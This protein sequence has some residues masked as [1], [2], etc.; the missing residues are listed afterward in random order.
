MTSKYRNIAVCTMTTTVTNS[1][2]DGETFA[3]I[4]VPIHIS[5]GIISTLGNLL[6][7]EATFRNKT[8]KKTTNILI[9]SLAFVDIAIGIVVTP[10]VIMNMHYVLYVEEGWVKCVIL[11]LS[12]YPLMMGGLGIMSLIVI[13]RYR[14]IVQFQKPPYTQKDITLMLFGMF[15][16]SLAM[17]GKFVLGIDCGDYDPEFVS[18]AVSVGAVWIFLGIIIWCYSRIVRKLRDQ[19]MMNNNRMKQTT[20]AISIYSFLACFIW[21]CI[22]LMPLI[23]AMLVATTAKNYFGTNFSVSAN[24]LYFY[25]L[26]CG[27]VNS[28]VNPFIYGLFNTKMRY[29]IVI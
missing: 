23:T 19:T 20:Q 28:M 26:T 29:V 27:L 17:S 9:G 14:A 8:L 22:C 5:I 1:T 18:T 3:K 21:Y 24:E 25:S 2:M 10:V 6:V 7:L 4:L 11:P 12:Y 16:A 15:I 13:E